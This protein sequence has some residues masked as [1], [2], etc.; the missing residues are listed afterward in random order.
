MARLKPTTNKRVDAVADELRLI[1]DDVEQA[2]PFLAQMY[3]VLAEELVLSIG[4]PDAPFRIRTPEGVDV[5]YD[6]MMSKITFYPKG[7]DEAK[8]QQ[9]LL[10]SVSRLQAR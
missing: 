9:R 3:R 2:R 6:G 5:S 10:A 7:F 8:Y 4:I 1:A